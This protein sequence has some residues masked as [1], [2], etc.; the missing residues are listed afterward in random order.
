MFFPSYQYIK[1]CLNVWEK[2]GLYDK[3]NSIKK[4]FNE[5]SYYNNYNDNIFI[6]P[7]N[8]FKQNVDQGEGG[9]FMSVFRGKISEGIN[10]MGN[11]TRM[12]INVGIPFIN[13][14]N[15][16][17]KLKEEYFML[18][19]K[20]F[21]KWYINDAI[22]AMNQSCG[23]IIRNK[24]DYGIILNIDNRNKDYLDFF[25]GWLKNANPKCED[26]KCDLNEYL[27]SNINKNEFIQ[28]I[29]HFYELWKDYENNNNF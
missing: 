3:I 24:N 21:N 4:I 23:R 16:K 27:E 11:Y 14:E 26:Y 28:E 10:L 17:F 19:N 5:I 1:D 13:K 2:E 15:A 18:N 7:I 8:L 22:L 20:D 29:K 12:L 6:E 9:I 25:S